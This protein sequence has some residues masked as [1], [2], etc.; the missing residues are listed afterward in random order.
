MRHSTSHTDIAGVNAVDNYTL[1]P[2]AHVVFY[3][4]N[5]GP[6][7]ITGL[8]PFASLR[9]ASSIQFE[10]LTGTEGPES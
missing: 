9:K 10:E 2:V 6:R 8:R 3:M 4:C 7:E 5:L 1:L